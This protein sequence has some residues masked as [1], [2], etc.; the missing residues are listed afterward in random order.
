MRM[1]STTRMPENTYARI[2]AGPAAAI[3]WPEPTNSPAPM[4]PAMESM[5][6]WRGL[7]PWERCESRSPD[8]GA[9]HN[10]RLL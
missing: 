4:M 7:K 6:T 3:A 9:N 10:Y 1:T 2:A 8:A 5:V